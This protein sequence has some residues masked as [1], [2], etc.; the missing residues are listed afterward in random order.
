MRSQNA[1]PKWWQI[2]LIFPLLIVLFILDHQLEIST[3]GHQAVQIGIVLIV[4]G[5]VH[6]WLR[7]NA[8]ALSGMN[9]ERAYG[10]IT[11]IQFPAFQPPESSSENRLMLQLPD[12]EKNSVLSDTFEMDYIDAVSLPVDE[13]PQELKKE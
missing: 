5:L 8:S 6:L 11:V 10:R 2:Y 7:A 3:R 4:Y 13:V 1:R 12:S 9:R